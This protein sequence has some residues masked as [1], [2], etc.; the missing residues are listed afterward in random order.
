MKIWLFSDIHLP[1]DEIPFERVFPGIP[2]AD[3]CICAGDLIESNPTAGVHW[4]SRHIR[5]AM[6]VLYVLGNHEFY[7]PRSN[8]E[9]ARRQAKEAADQVGIHLLDDASVTIGGIQFHGST[10]WSDFSI[11][12]RGSLAERDCAMAETGRALNDFH[13][14]RAR[15]GSTDLWTPKMAMMQHFHSRFWLDEELANGAVRNIV[16]SHHAPH[17]LSVAPQFAKDPVTAGFVS[18][19]SELIMRHQPTLWVHGHTHTA[20]DY[21]VGSTMVRCNP[22]GYRHEKVLGFDPLRVIEV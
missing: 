12:A 19:L 6:P 20:F 17:P 10:L 21:K 18:D 15:E 3:V 13:L 1:H 8:M 5:P 22:K 11:L 14:I 7:N 2:D 4:L 16:V 9:R